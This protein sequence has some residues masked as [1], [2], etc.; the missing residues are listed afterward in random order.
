MDRKVIISKTAQ[1]KFDNLFE[2]LVD[3]WLERVKNKFIEKLDKS[4]HVI[5]TNPEAF[6]KSD[7]AK[8]LRRC[9]ITKQTTLYFR[10]NNKRIEVVTIFDTRQN[11]NKL[12]KSLK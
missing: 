9:V 5:R 11:P 7:K 8:G 2:Y 12:K 1:K 3:E 4:I 6:P 10:Y